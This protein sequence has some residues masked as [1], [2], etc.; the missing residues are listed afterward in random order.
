[1]NTNTTEGKFDQIKGKVKQSAGE[2]FG[3]QK[4]ANSGTADRVKGSVK[5][6][7]GNAQDAVKSVAD[8]AHAH[9][10]AHGHDVRSKIAS[11]AQNVKDSINA[12]ADHIKAEHKR[13]A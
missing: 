3:N 13:S 10:E 7:W 4:L 6:A 2:A 5:E 12:K 9:A 11:T 8:D 1:M